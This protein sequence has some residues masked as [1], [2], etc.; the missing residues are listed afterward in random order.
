M[1]VIVL[2]I[3]GIAVAMVI[4]SVGVIFSNRC[5]RGSCGG[6]EVLGADGEP[7]AC[8]VCPRRKMPQG[9]KARQGDSHARGVFRDVN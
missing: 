3:V 1:G 2:S 8:D 7:L 4:M 9:E 6:A 5:L